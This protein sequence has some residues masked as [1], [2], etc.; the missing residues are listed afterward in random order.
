MM[1][2]PYYIN[3]DSELLIECRCLI[4]SAEQSLQLFADNAR[5]AAHKDGCCFGDPAQCTMFRALDRKFG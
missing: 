4:D 5:M 2:C 3:D 1:R